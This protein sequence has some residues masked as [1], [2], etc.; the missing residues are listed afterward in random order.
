MAGREAEQPITSDCKDF[1]KVCASEGA[2]HGD[3]SCF[4][5]VNVIAV[6]IVLG[7]RGV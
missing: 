2:G 7:F 6:R 1:Y 5:C 3:C 4:L